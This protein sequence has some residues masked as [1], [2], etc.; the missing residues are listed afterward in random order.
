[1]NGNRVQARIYAGYGKTADKV[2]FAYAH[3]RSAMPINPLGSAN[4][5]DPINVAFS[6][7]TRPFMAYAKWSDETWIAHA[8]GRRLQ[9]RDFLVGPGGTYYV[10]DMQPLLPIQAVRCTHTAARIERPIYVTG[11][12]QQGSELIASGLPFGLKLKSVNVK[13]PIG[14]ANTAG[15]GISNWLAFVPMAETTLKRNDLITDTEG[16]QYEVDAPAWTPMGYVAQVRL[17]NP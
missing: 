5:L 16:V 9:P 17:A 2:G 1:M 4:L 10:G 3:F 14:A 13:I 15:V 7:L 12:L 8:D 11:S 6:T